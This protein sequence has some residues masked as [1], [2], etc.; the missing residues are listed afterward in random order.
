MVKLSK[1]K[2]SLPLEDGTDSYSRNVG[3]KQSWPRNNPEDG[4]IR[5]VTFQL[6]IG[7]NEL[8]EYKSLATPLW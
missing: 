5:L 3:F 7:P 4:I 2:D 1:K 8:E 6:S